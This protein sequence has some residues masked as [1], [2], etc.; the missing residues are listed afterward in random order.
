[1]ALFVVALTAWCFNRNLFH[2]AIGFAAIFTGGLGI[3]L[4]VVLY[5]T[6]PRDPAGS[7]DTEPSDAEPTDNDTAAPPAADTGEPKSP[8]A[9]AA[10]PDEP[11]ETQVNAEID[12]E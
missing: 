7:E 1:M 5:F 2:G 11:A 6:K 12:A 3:A 10:T 9:S 4:F 8:D